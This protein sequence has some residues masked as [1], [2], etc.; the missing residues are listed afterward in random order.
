MANANIVHSGYGF[1]CTVT[2]QNLP[3][4][5]GLDGCAVLE[6]LTGLPDG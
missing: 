5:L 3:L 2:E 1:R 6:R 4:T